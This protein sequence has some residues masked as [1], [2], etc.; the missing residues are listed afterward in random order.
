MNITSG[1]TDHAWLHDPDCAILRV[2]RDVGV[3]VEQ[4][5]N[6]MPD[7]GVHDGAAVR[8]RDGFAAR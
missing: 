4:V 2:V 8:V 7:K 6:T 1:P 5:M 3:P